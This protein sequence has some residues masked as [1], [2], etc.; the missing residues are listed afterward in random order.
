MTS[1]KNSAWQAL[2]YIGPK[3]VQVRYFP[4]AT[5]VTPALD[6]H[7]RCCYVGYTCWANVRNFT[8]MWN[9]NKI[10][11]IPL[12]ENFWILKT[13]S[14]Q[15]AHWGLIDNMAALVQIMAW[16]DH[17]WWLNLLTHIWGTRPQWLLLVSIYHTNNL[18]LVITRG[19]SGNL[20]SPYITT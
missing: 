4:W 14:L 13:I 6:I 7:V 18:W 2:K 15:Y 5:S 20:Y 1:N 8:L 16:A 19:H 12:N 10:I 11:C 17:R 9:E 3:M